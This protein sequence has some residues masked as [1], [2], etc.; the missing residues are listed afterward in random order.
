MNLLIIGHDAQE[1]RQ[2]LGP[3]FPELSL[4]AVAD[5]AAAAQFVDSADILM[6]IRVSDDL[7][8]R[9]ARLQWIQSIISGTDYFEELPTFRR[10]D[11]LLLT[12]ARGIHGPQMSELAIML[13]LALTR[14]FPSMVRNQAQKIWDARPAALLWQKTV[15]ILGVGVVG[16]AIAQKCKAFGMR[17]LGIGPHP[18]DCEALNR[19]FDLADLH[20][21]MAEVDYFICV[22]PSNPNNRGLLGAEAFA[23]MKP[24][25]YFLNLGRGELVDE[26]ALITALK[27]RRIA[28]A[29]LDTY[30]HEPLPPDHPFW[31]MD[32]I[33]ITPHI[34]GMSDIYVRQ[35]CTI[36]EQ[37]LRLFLSGERQG[38]LNVVRRRTRSA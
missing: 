21:V 29:A 8:A 38:L 4:H 24:T 3:K 31:E 30:C 15:G 7:L 2:M 35:A 18:R 36:I 26:S 37:N 32:N 5:E 10:R 17:V 20:Q 16:T 9:A 25:A 12:S 33:I 1:F 27:E 6:A 23:R 22:A 11:D 28:G 14:G 19:F 34:G 13:M